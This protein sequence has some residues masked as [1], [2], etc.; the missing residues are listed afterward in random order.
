MYN[1]LM[2]GIDLTKVSR[3]KNKSE[4]FVKRVL[5]AEEIKEYHNSNDKVFY[6]AN[7]WAIKEALFKA[8]N[9]LSNFNEI[10]ITK[11]NGVYN[12]IN[13]EISTSNEDGYIVAIARKEE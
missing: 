2:L 4:T 10:R 13:F 5:N 9:R 1:F 8:D 7:A 11:S 3:F 6:L 12:Y